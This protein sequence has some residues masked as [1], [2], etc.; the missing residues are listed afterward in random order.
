MGGSNSFGVP[1]QETSI[2]VYI[3]YIYVQ[4][5]CKYNLILRRVLNSQLTLLSSASCIAATAFCH[6]GSLAQENWGSTERLYAPV[7]AECRIVRFSPPPQNVES[8][9]SEAKNTPTGESFKCISAHRKTGDQT[10]HREKNN[11]GP[12]SCKVRSTKQSNQA[13]LNHS[14]RPHH[15][16]DCMRYKKIYGLWRPFNDFRTRLA[17]VHCHLPP[18]WQCVH[19]LSLECDTLLL[20][21]EQIWLVVSTPLKNISQL[22]LLSPIYGKIKN[23]PNHQP[24]MVKFECVLSFQ[25]HDVIGI[26]RMESLWSSRE[27]SPL[28]FI[29]HLRPATEVTDF[30][31]SWE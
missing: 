20:G 26:T 5:I 31:Q 10:S 22:G 12:F 19:G 18:T 25:L 24:V 4:S 21:H 2:Y 13:G 28:L 27:S 9:G 29:C 8:S 6:L 15:I 30:P 23:G 3:I 17:N 7:M 14:K 16:E 11:D 1:L